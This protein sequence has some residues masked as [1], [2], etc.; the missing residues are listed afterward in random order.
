MT[1]AKQLFSVTL[2]RTVLILA[3]DSEDALEIAEDN[4]SDI[5]DQ[6][7]EIL[8]SPMTDMPEGWS[9]AIP[10]SSPDEPEKTVHEWISEGAAPKYTALVEILKSAK[11]P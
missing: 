5:N 1:A 4:E 3:N 10:F 2:T 8:A 11:L 9:D 6:D 7:A